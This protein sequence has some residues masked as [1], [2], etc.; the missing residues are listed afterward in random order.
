MR[1][2]LLLFTLIAGSILAACPLPMDS[3]TAMPWPGSSVHE[4]RIIVTLTDGKTHS[5][6]EHT[7]PRSIAVRITNEKIGKLP[8]WRRRLSKVIFTQTLGMKVSENPVTYEGLYAPRDPNGQ[9]WIYFTLAGWKDCTKKSPCLGWIARGGVIGSDGTRNDKNRQVYIGISSDPNFVHDVIGRPSEQEGRTVTKTV[10]MQ[11]EWDALL[12]QSKSYCMVNPNL[13]TV[14]FVDDRGAH[15]LTGLTKL[16]VSIHGMFT[17]V[18]KDALH[19]QFSG[20]IT[21]EGY[22]DPVFVEVDPHRPSHLGERHWHYFELIGGDRRCTIVSP[23]FGFYTAECL[24]VVIPVTQP[25][26]L[27][28]ETLG[29]YGILCAEMMAKFEKHF[30]KDYVWLVSEE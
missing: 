7:G 6:L 24:A 3:L 11:G 16:D 9:D 12:V 18:I 13:A 21:F 5:K 14:T 15:M 23:C 17:Q 27:R 30:M 4:D 8:D 19:L 22:Y 2:A 28:F 29:T 26:P 10:G 20:S 25:S 1:S